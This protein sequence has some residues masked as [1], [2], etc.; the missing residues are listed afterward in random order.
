MFS[1]TGLDDARLQ[2]VVL[3]ILERAHELDAENLDAVASALGLKAWQELLPEL[4]FEIVDTGG[5][6]GLVRGWGASSGDGPYVL[7]VTDGEAGLP[8][9]PGTFQVGISQEDDDHELYFVSVGRGI[10]R[11]R[12]GLLVE[13]GRVPDLM[14]ALPG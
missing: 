13:E 5:G 9:D 6:F 2:R 10:V 12:G 8:E 1:M 3:E 14:P 11:W 4:E 7:D